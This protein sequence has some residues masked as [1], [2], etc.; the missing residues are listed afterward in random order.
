MQ[1][2]PAET[3]SPSLG[4]EDKL[5][6]EEKTHLIAELKDRFKK[7]KAVV[8]TDYKGLTVAEL[9]EL[10]RLL[11]GAG[12]EYKVVKNTLA[13]A[14]SAKTSLSVISDLLKGPVGIA[15]GYADPA[16]VAKKIIEYS[17][18]N[19]KLKV[20]GG[21]VEGMLCNAEDIKSIA[22]LPPREI[23][24]GMLAGVFNAPL[25]KMAAALSATV[26]SF[27]YAAEALKNKKS[28]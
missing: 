17:K 3:L 21:V 14:A 2:W 9:F 25:S 7:A 22:A 27:A 10:R 12:I 5:K 26:G 24:L 13:R 15:I 19:N 18:K 20:S 28:A 4:K 8:L 16:Q 1:G 6:R 23:L 11:R